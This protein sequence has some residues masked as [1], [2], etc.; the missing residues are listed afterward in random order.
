MKKGT[1]IGD[2]IAACEA[3]GFI[4]NKEAKALRDTAQHWGADARL[5]V[6]GILRRGI[7]LQQDVHLLMY[8]ASLYEEEENAVSS[9][10]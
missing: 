7:L 2:V 4:S 10:H 1:G 6:E 3:Q 9:K 8:W 5:Y